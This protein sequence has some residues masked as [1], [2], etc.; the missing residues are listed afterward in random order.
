MNIEKTNKEKANDVAEVMGHMMAKGFK[1]AFKIFGVLG[2][3]MFVA[4]YCALLGQF[5]L[6]FAIN[7]ILF[8]IMALRARKKQNR[9]GEN[10]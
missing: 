9:K 3:F 4:I 10:K 6:G 2:V 5:A 7:S 1:D 8:I